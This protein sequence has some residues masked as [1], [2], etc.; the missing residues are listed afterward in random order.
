[1]QM[2]HAQHTHT[3]KKSEQTSGTLVHFDI[4][5]SNITVQQWQKAVVGVWIGMLLGFRSQGH[6]PARGLG[7]KSRVKRE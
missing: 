4:A 1:M 3:Q 2:T 6:L 5:H 7:L